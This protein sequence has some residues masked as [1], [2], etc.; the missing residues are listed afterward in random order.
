[1]GKHKKYSRKKY[2]KDRKRRL[3]SL[4]KVEQEELGDASNPAEELELGNVADASEVDQETGDDG[5]I[6]DKEDNGDIFKDCCMDLNDPKVQRLFKPQHDP[7]WVA[8]CKFAKNKRKWSKL[9]ENPLGNYYEVRS[10]EI[11]IL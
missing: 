9:L 2:V 8:F 1:M 6:N 5:D 4:K 3:K 11:T 7:L 10:N